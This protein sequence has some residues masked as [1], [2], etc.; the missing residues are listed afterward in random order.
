MSHNLMQVSYDNSSLQTILLEEDNRFIRISGSI[1]HP[2]LLKIDFETLVSTSVF[3]MLKAMSIWKFL[4][5]Q[6]FFKTPP[7]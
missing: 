6:D 5:A 4:K 1:P 7:C 2:V 3:W